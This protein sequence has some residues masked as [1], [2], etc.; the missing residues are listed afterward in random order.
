MRKIKPPKQISLR[1][2][3]KILTNNVELI[4]MLNRCGQGIDYFQL[5]EINTALR[6]QKMASTSE[7]LL[8]GNIQPHDSTILALDNI[9]RLDEMFSGK[10]TS[11]RVFIAVTCQKAFRNARRKNLL[12]V[13]VR[14]HADAS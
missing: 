2:A 4:Q 7:I 6:L 1:Y 11:H 8:P 14:L 12:W 3:V 13:L 9:D 10:G 5:E